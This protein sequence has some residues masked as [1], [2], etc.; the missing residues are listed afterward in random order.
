M[1]HARSRKELAEVLDDKEVLG[2]EVWSCMGADSMEGASSSVGAGLNTFDRLASDFRL[3]LLSFRNKL[4]KL[5]RDWFLRGDTGPEAETRDIPDVTEAGDCGRLLSYL[6]IE[7]PL[8]FRK[9]T[10]RANDVR[11]DEAGSRRIECGAET[12]TVSSDGSGSSR[13]VSTTEAL[14]WGGINSLRTGAGGQG[15]SL[16][17]HLAGIWWSGIPLDLARSSR[18]R[19]RASSSIPSGKTASR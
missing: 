15:G 11:V 9:G 8:N 12:E 14:G 13:T 3:L 5:S 1:K 10:L 17:M 7:R 2:D 19:S 6:I 18:W 16:R 4:M